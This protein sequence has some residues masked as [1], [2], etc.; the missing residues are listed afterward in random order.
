MGPIYS[1]RNY[2]YLLWRM[3]KIQKPE[4]TDSER[5][6]GISTVFYEDPD[7]SHQGLDRI[8][9]DIDEAYKVRN[10]PTIDDV[11]WLEQVNQR[12]ERGIDDEN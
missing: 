9:D 11:D 5:E 6:Y 1:L 10:Q 3:L 12:M 4:L 7:N 8:I 2:E